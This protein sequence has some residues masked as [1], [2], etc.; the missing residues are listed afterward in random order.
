MM[1]HMKSI[2]R[3]L[4]LFALFVPQVPFAQEDAG[5]S[6]AVVELFTGR[7][8]TKAAPANS[9]LKTIFERQYAYDGDVI[10]LSCHVMKYKLNSSSMKLDHRLCGERQ[11][12]Y[13]RANV[14]DSIQIPQIVINGKFDMGGDREH[15]IDSGI[16]MA[17]SL[18]RIAPLD[19]RWAG[20]ELKVD[21]PDFPLDKP[22]NLWLMGY[23]HMNVFESEEEI[24]GEVKKTR[25]EY[26]NVVRH[27]KKIS[28]DEGYERAFSYSLNKIPADGYAV[29]VQ[30]RGLTEMLAA[31]KIEH[32]SLENAPL[33]YTQDPVHFIGKSSHA[34]R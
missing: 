27:I 9:V 32:F 16:K 31:G 8:C 4:F 2:I 5:P 22:L 3:F 28:L 10:L 19:V 17:H 30:Y 13:N 7:G 15:I 20:D 18:R 6:V 14:T 23:E 34:T 21:L 29:I 33:S 12:L 24:A 1:K 11:V 25:Q 26:V